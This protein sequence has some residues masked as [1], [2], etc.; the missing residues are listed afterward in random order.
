MALISLSVDTC[1]GS[2]V[3]C[4][5]QLEGLKGSQVT[6]CDETQRCFK[7]AENVACQISSLTATM[8]TILGSFI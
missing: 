6:Y 7:E 8:K 1:S 2:H 5:F 4:A 3:T